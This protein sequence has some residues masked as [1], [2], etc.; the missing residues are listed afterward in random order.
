[1]Y[2]LFRDR[3]A[4]DE[5]MAMIR[6]P[7]YGAFRNHLMIPGLQRGD[8]AWNMWWFDGEP[9]QLVEKVSPDWNAKIA[10]ANKVN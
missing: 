4:V 5:T 9:A 2:P 3:R 1:M 10:D 7:R 6:S 8:I